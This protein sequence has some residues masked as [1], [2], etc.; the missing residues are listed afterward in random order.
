MT[1]YLVKHTIVTPPVYAADNGKTP[2]HTQAIQQAY[3]FMD[4]NSADRCRQR[5][6]GHEWRVVSARVENGIIVHVN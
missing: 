4:W 6:L 2:A 1:V 3:R 5:M